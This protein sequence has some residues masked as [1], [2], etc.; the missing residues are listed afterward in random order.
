[1]I[2]TNEETT[3]E[4]APETPKREAWGQAGLRWGDWKWRKEEP[5][6]T[7]EEEVPRG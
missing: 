5:K 2:T 3:E 4:T 7:S 1:M 6:T